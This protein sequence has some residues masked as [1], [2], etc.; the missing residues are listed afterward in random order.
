MQC[1][2]AV[3]KINFHHLFLKM[4]AVKDVS[5]FDNAVDTLLLHQASAK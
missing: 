4:H 1:R 2:T 3:V 5:E